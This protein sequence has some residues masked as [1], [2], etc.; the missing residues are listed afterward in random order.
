[1]EKVKQ[2]K[3]WQ[4]NRIMKRYLESLKKLNKEKMRIKEEKSKIFRKN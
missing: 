3:E 1:M 4:S 2:N